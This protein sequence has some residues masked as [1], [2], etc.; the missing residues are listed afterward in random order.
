MS[1]LKVDSGEWEIWLTLVSIMKHQGSEEGTYWFKGI[2]ARECHLPWALMTL[3]TPRLTS[4]R[5]SMHHCQFLRGIGVGS[6]AW[7][8]CSGRKVR[9][10]LLP[11]AHITELLIPL[12]NWQQCSVLRKQVKN[13]CATPPTTPRIGWSVTH[14]KWAAGNAIF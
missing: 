8:R 5:S 3:L 13:T 7:C 12:R 4:L 14:I 9:L 11:C 1:R 10:A 6:S 2:W